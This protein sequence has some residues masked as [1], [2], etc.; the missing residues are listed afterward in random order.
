MLLRTQKERMTASGK[1]IFPSNFGIFTEQ[2]LNGAM[3]MH[4]GPINEGAEV[5]KFL[6]YQSK[7]SLIS[8]QVENGVKVRTAVLRYILK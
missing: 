1:I 6:A 3:L 8:K 5:S 7:K 4:P 2:D